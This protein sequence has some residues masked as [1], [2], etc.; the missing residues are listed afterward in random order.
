[1]LA[2]AVLFVAAALAGPPAAGPHAPEPLSVGF[3]PPADATRAPASA[4]GEWLRALP[5][6]PRGTSVL[7]HAGAVLDMPAA[8]VVALPLVP[9]DLQHCADSILRLRATWERETGRS[10]VFHYTSGYRS[11]FADWAAGFRPQVSGNKVTRRSGGR[12]GTDDANFQAWLTDL[13]I[14]AGTRSLAKE[15]ATRQ[16]ADVAPG[17]LLVAP[18]S[19]GH[20]V[21]VL[22]VARAGER[23][24]VLVGQGFMPAMSFHVVAGPAA[25]WY[26]VA[27][28]TLPTAPI[29]LP[30]STL[31][32]F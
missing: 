10:P 26:P 18:G 32:S 24:W 12:T 29:P 3:P 2:N 13:F 22:D 19:P 9:G 31:A 8:R 23:T 20:A 17:D 16:V 28:E 5:L 6:E 30:W 7:S 21:L 1:M 14:Y 4:W 15:V 27:G 11:S 25:G